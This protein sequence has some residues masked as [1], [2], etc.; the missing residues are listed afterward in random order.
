M[1]K[2]PHIG[3]ICLDI[4]DRLNVRYEVYGGPANC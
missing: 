1:L 4:L 2:T 3:L